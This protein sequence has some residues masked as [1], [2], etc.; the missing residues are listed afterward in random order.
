MRGA[1]RAYVGLGSNLG[2]PAAQIA[3]AFDALAVLPSTTLVA[4]SRL[5]RSAAWG[6][7]DQPDYIN[8]V[9]ALDTCLAP[10]ALMASLLAIERAAGRVRDARWGPRLIDLDLLLHGDCALDSDTLTLPHPRLHERA[11]VLLPLAELAP[12]LVIPG[13]GP[14]AALCNSV[15]RSSIEALG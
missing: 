14:L 3:A 7:I 8:A 11:F 5:Y 2:D 6:P 9:A 4:R 15:D 10:E 1:L 13:H 12:T